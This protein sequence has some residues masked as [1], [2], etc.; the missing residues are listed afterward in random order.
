MRQH[1]KTVGVRHALRDAHLAKVTPLDGHHVLQV[2]LKPIRREE[3][4]P[5]VLRREALTVRNLRVLDPVVARARVEHGGMRQ[6]RP[7]AVRL[8][9]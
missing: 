8:D 6:K 7:A 1:H 4:C 3:W 9:S 5:H 2:A